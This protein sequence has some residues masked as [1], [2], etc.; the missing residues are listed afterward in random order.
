[1]LKSTNLREDD[2]DKYEHILEFY[3]IHLDLNQEGR[4]AKSISNSASPSRK[5]LSRSPTPDKAGFFKKIS[6]N[7]KTQ[8]NDPYV[9]WAKFTEGLLERR[10]QKMMS[11]I[12]RKFL[13]KLE[14][15]GRRLRPLSQNRYPLAKDKLH[16]SKERFETSPQRYE[17]HDPNQQVFYATGFTPSRQDFESVEEQNVISRK[18]NGYHQRVNSSGGKETPLK[19]KEAD[20]K[21][22]AIGQDGLSPQTPKKMLIEPKEGTY[23]SIAK[24]NTNHRRT[25]TEI[26]SGDLYAKS[27]RTNV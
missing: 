21:K 13:Q 19:T 9:L 1:M 24:K 3:R 11:K 15:R 18:N 5:R 17:L 23:S 25:K 26:N 7:N 2:P 6:V 27:A 14:K 16:K 10:Q 12:T 4:E 22:T 8:K 20:Y